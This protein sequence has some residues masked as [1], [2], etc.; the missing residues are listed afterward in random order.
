MGRH[1][2]HAL[3]VTLA[4]CIL[5]EFIEYTELAWTLIELL[6]LIAERARIVKVSA[7]AQR[8]LLPKSDR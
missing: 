7:P 4:S 6:L 2:F 1:P 8:H 5:L 3:H